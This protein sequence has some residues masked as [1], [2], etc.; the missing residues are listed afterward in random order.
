MADWEGALRLGV[1][2]GLF[3][4]LVLLEL[5]RP[6]RPAQRQRWLANLGLLALGSIAVRLMFPV[7][8]TG[9]ALWAERQSLG[10]LNQWES[11]PSIQIVLAVLALDGAI[12]WQ[13]RIFH[14]FP[15]LWRIHRVHHADTALDVTTGLRFHP[16]ELVLSMVIKSAFIVM[17]GAPALAVLIFEVLL[18]ACSMFN[19]SNIVLPAKLERGLRR[20]LITPTL[21]RIHHS[22]RGDETNSNF[23]FSVPW[24]DYVFGSF[25]AAA[26]DGDSAVRIGLP[27]EKQYACRLSILLLLPFRLRQSAPKDDA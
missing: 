25:R 8:A 9:A 22:R 11:S 4:A 20:V 18:N 3:I 2:S 13:H 14:R 16:V 6:F 17:L 21:H 26:R 27:G 24:W 23:G 1:F 19:H 5:W 12:Y 7:A 10:L 15:W